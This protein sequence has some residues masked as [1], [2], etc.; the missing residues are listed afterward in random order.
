[1]QKTIQAISE[2]VGDEGYAFATVTPLFHRDTDSRIV[3]ITFDIEKGR[4]V[5]VERIDVAGNE[6]TD[7]SVIRREMRQDEGARY[8]ASKVRRSKERLHRLPYLDDVR[9]SLPKG[10]NSQMTRM[11]VEVDEKKSG[12]F[13]FGI[14]YSQLD[15]LFFKSKLQ[16]KN[17]FG[18]G[19]QASV[20][21]T[22]GARTKNYTLGFTDPYFLDN[23]ISASVGFHN[24]QSNALQQVQRNYDTKSTGG[25]VDFGIPLT[26]T[27]SY[28]IGYQFDKT[29]LSNIPASASLLTK[30]QGGT[31]TTGELTTSIAYDTRDRVVAP[32]DGNIERLSLS[33]A[34]LGGKDHFYTANAS[35]ALY[36]PLDKEADF[37]LNP[38]VN[39]S[40]IKAQRG[41]AIPLYRR[42]SLGGI[43]SVRGFDSYGISVRDP[44][45]GEAL[46]GDKMFTAG[47]NLF[48]PLPYMK[49]AGFRALVFFD[50][51]TT[52]G[53][54]S[55]TVA[56]KTL[57][58]TE[59]FSFAKIRASTGFGIEWESPIGPIG[60]VWAFPVK[61]QQ[62]DIKRQ[63]EFA[64]GAQF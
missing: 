58:V 49:T 20:D 31:H 6:K 37:V 4:E 28:S 45:T 46:G 9:V 39:F 62:G 44:A 11:R 1:M 14:G 35:S 55:A 17:L 30:S 54:V 60:M 15:K 61:K 3:D 33:Y 26:E 51:G 10:S 36:Q 53:N 8:S 7:D 64:L 22:F 34:G 5:Y 18:K 52:W 48:F 21:G 27:I 47:M 19:Y 63:F 41:Y 29:S 56:G 50:A 40:M 23:D 12:S 25:N 2:R 57:N 16:E 24:T 32:R 38:S 42:F 43:G 59:P 13:T